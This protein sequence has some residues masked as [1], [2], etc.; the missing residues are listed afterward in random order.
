MTT[1]H[2]RSDLLAETNE[3][4][5]HFILTEIDLA[6]TFA[7]TAI[8][9]DSEEKRDRNANNA[10]KGYETA[11]AFIKKRPLRE[12]DR[13]EVQSRLEPLKK[14]LL[15]LGKIDSDGSQSG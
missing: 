9:T 8:H 15:H 14:A 6:M 2:N 5:Y 12:E 7:D 13:K 11:M 4:L 10:S 1:P 3:N